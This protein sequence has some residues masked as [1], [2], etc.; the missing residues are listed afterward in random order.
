MLEGKGQQWREQ[1]KGQKLENEAQKGAEEHSSP[2][3]QIGLKTSVLLQAPAL[4][5]WLMGSDTSSS[6]HPYR[7]IL[8]L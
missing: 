6:T 7:A 8:L 1:G 4:C 2:R 3:I 5:T